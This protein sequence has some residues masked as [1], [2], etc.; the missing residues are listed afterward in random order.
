M[1]LGK[2]RYV[3]TC[4]QLLALGVV[5]AALVPAASIVTL[6]VVR[7][8]PSGTASP[9]GSGGDG[10]TVVP[11]TAPTPSGALAAY[12]KAALTPSTVATAATDASVDEVQLT[13]PATTAAGRRAVGAKTAAKAGAPTRNARI[14]R[15]AT[16]AT[17]LSTPQKV[18]GFGT[19]GVTWQH[20]ENLK[21]SRVKVQLRT[22]KGG[23][24]SGWHKVDYDVDGP[25]ADTA[26]GKRSRPGTMEAL[27]GHVDQV[28]VRM[29][30]TGAH[31]PADLK[32]AVIAPGQAPTASERPALD[33][34]TMGAGET[35]GSTPAERAVASGPAADASSAAGQGQAVLAA[36]AYTPKPQIYSRAQWGADEKIREQTAPSYAEV[37]GGFVHH[38]VNA[39]DYTAAEVPGI[40][41]SIYAYHVRSRG[42]RDIG[43]NFLIDRF[44]RI[45]EGRYGG[46]DRP[47]VGAHTENY[48]DY[49]FGVSAIG[50]FETAK[51][52]SA[53]IQAEGALFGWKLS[54]HGVSAAA[55]NVAIGPKRFASSIMGHRDTKSTACPGRYLYNK[56]PQ[57]RSLAAAVQVGWSGRTLESSFV[58]T[59]DPDLV[60]RDATTK[61][62]YVIPTASAAARLTVPA[63][64]RGRR[65]QS[66]TS[67]DLTGDRRPDLV[68]VTKRGVA[69]IRPG[70]G[71]GH[72]GKAVRTDRKKFVDRIL[73]TAVGDINRDGHNDLVAKIKKAGKNKGRLSIYLGRGN[74]TFVRKAQ[75]SVNLKGF[76]GLSGPGDVTGDGRPDLVARKTNGTTVT[77]PG[78]GNGTFGAPLSTG[79]VPGPAGRTGLGAPINT[80]LRLPNAVQLLNAGDW[81]RDGKSD[82][83]A[84]NTDGTL[85]LY[86]G[87]GQGRFSAPI[88]IGRGFGGVKL[89]SA[90]G[91]ITGDGWPDLQGQSSGAMR[92]WPGRGAAGLG[93]AYVS[94]SAITAK[95]QVAVGRWD[96][97]GAP[98]ALFVKGKKT[99]LYPG[100]GPGGLTNPITVG[101]SL[102]G[103]TWVIGVGNVSATGKS[104]L[105]VRNAAG[106]LYRIDPT[107]TGALGTPQ[108]IGTG[109]ARY[110]LAG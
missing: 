80:G 28:Q 68:K 16:K 106:S 15:T 7:E 3:A 73:V 31:V 53:L 78:T 9:G 99:L 30:I 104:A 103:Y 43:Y 75:H 64:V 12:T 66:I 54:L 69:K 48:N 23:V 81:N 92:I 109:Y 32:L 82:L 40:I 62:L 42:W 94:H 97:D 29:R 100:N 105:I 22:E 57:I 17:I 36:A 96:A 45:W 101:G 18:T 10:G 93:A 88:V 34:S 89:L 72:Y 4:Q 24:W 59:S 86:L 21:P 49:G 91:D 102:A 85:N 39:N 38:T 41:R 35:G 14:A 13:T 63:G 27:V 46:V 70:D 11:A 20:G 79:A 19:V 98:D 26:E 55:T 56:I 52:T 50:N 87:N 33:T 37:H 67:P 110:D 1:H 47:V 83:I 51:P 2:T 77:L 25:D 74:G 61:V 108:L 5:V 84:R 95:Q 44:G 8:T 71:A 6:D 76:T 90:A 58:G 65:A 107:S 60:V